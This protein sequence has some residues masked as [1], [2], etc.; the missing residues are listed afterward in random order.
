MPSEEMEAEQVPLVNTTAYLARDGRTIKSE[1]EANKT[2][3][4]HL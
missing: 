4:E 2:D 1:C 3:R